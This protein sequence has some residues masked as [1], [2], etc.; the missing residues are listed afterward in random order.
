MK[1]DERSKSPFF[2]SSL[3]VLGIIVG[4]CIAFL[5]ITP[6]PLRV[7]PWELVV[8][9]NEY[10]QQTVQVPGC[11][12]IQYTYTLDSGLNPDPRFTQYFIRDEDPADGRTLTL[13]GAVAFLHEGC[14]QTLTG[15]WEASTLTLHLGS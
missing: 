2:W 7:E 10:D 1:M 5:R 8:Q 9:G 13:D 11:V 15:R 3:V 12:V 6:P 4:L 14:G